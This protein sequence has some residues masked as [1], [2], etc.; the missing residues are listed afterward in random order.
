M[1]FSSKHLRSKIVIVDGINELKT[2]IFVLCYLTVLAY[3]K[4]SVAS[5]GYRLLASST[6][7]N[8][9]VCKNLYISLM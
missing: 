8:T 9:A 1:L 3:T 7:V 2:V 5:E 6:S 4:A